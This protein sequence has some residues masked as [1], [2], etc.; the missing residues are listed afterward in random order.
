[1]KTAFL[2][3]RLF[4]LRPLDESGSQW[5]KDIEEQ[6]RQENLEPLV[7]YIVGGGEQV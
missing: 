7:S 3:T 2:K 1:M 4:P 6:A 5:L